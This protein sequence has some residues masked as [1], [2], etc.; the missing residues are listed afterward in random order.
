MLAVSFRDQGL[1]GRK[2]LARNA[3]TKASNS[4]N[5]Q[6]AGSGGVA[7]GAMRRTV[8]ASVKRDHGGRGD[9]ARGR[10]VPTSKD[11]RECQRDVRLEVADRLVEVGQVK[12][13]IVPLPVRISIGG[14]EPTVDQG[15][16]T[17]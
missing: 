10:G 15:Q 4:A 1:G 11:R 9:L 8:P 12:A 16:E 6:S 13:E 5:S 7:G 3:S 14:V 2:P 17:R